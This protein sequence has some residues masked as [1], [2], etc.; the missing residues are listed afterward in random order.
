MLSSS[1]PKI[2]EPCVT[3]V[4]PRPTDRR[5]HQ[6][7]RNTSGA[8]G[9]RVL[10]HVMRPADTRV[11]G[12]WAGYAVTSCDVHVLVYEAAEAVSS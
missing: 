6:K 8:C 1:P 9:C 3:G 10:G 11:P 12:L 5:Q 7:L 4:S 2:H